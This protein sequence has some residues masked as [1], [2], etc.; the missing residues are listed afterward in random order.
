M[1]AEISAEVSSC[2]VFDML[3]MHDEWTFQDAS[4]EDV[5]AFR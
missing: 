4:E 2:S 1:F 5:A 3:C